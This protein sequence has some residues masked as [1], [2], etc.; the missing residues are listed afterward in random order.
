MRAIPRLLL[1][2]LVLGASPALGGAVA[3]AR[4]TQEPTPQ[5]EVLDPGAE[6]REAL[7][8]APAAGASEQAAMTVRLGI[9]LSGV[10]ERSLKTPPLRATIAASLQE[11]TPNGDLRV[12][13]TYP[14]FEVLKGGGGSPAE[15][16][17]IQDALAGLG[18]LTGEL[19]LTPQGVPLDSKLDIPPGL[20]P[21]VSGLLSQ[22]R[23]QFRDITVRLPE[24]AVGVGARWRATAQLTLNGI[25]GQQVYEYRLKR[26]TGSTAE[27]DIRGTQTAKRQTVDTP[28]G[29]RLRVKSFKTTFRGATTLDLTRILPVSSR[30]RG[31]GDQTFELRSGGQSGEVRQHID[32]GVEIERT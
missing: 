2:L 7:R 29:V 25:Q 23:D 22:L 24:P 12:S 9:K 16:R 8:L 1:A 19:T 28:G 32:L 3:G 27:L 5:I 21:T 4:P 17:K 10:S 15:R 26:L 18:G 31:S 14:S 6:P 11:V 13:L 20:D 30:V